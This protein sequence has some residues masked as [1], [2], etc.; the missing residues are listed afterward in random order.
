MKVSLF[1]GLGIATI[2]LSSTA[3]ARGIQYDSGQWDTTATFPG[4]ISNGTAVLDIAPDVT[5]Q[6]S[7]GDTSALNFATGVNDSGALGSYYSS[8]SNIASTVAYEFNWGSNPTSTSNSGIQD[9]IIVYEF[10]NDSP[11]EVDFN[12]SGTSCASA[13]ATLSILQLSDSNASSTNPCAN[14]G[15]TANVVRLSI[16]LNND[17]GIGGL[18]ESVFGNWMYA[19][20]GP[21]VS[22]PEIDLGSASAGLTA[23]LCSV[24]IIAGRRRGRVSGTR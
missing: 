16:S 12:Y 14:T 13:A 2:V 20:T 7:P 3:V 10:A 1:F 5:L 19:S 15:A 23:M 4:S 11:I 21:T 8:I 6:M 18:G 9:Q 24:A 17:G 22:A